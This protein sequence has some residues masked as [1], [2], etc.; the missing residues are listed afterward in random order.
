MATQKPRNRIVVFRLSQEEFATLKNACAER[1]GRN[2]S[3]FTRSEIIRF[4]NTQSLSY[5]VER[6]FDE[7]ERRLADLS[8]AV[9]EVAR[10]QEP[11]PPAVRA[12]A[13]HAG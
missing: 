4:L 5:V 10:R 13:A 6:H 3:E 1:G 9:D 11:A 7:L 12:A 2:L 8:A